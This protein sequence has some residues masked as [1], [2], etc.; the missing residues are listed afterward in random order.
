[1]RILT[2][3]AR[4]FLDTPDDL[5]GKYLIDSQNVVRESWVENVYQI[6]DS[7]FNE[8][9]IFIDVG[10][11]IGAVSLF[12]S[13]F[14]SNRDENN[15]IKIYA[16]EPEIHNLK[17]LSSNVIKNN[18]IE[19][20]KIETSALSTKEGNSYISN[21]GGNSMLTS[22][23]SDCSEIK[24]ITLEQL[25]NKYEINQCDVLKMDIEGSEYEVLINSSLETLKR[26]KYLTLEFTKTNAEQFGELISHLAEIFNLHII[27][28]PSNG[29]YIYGRRY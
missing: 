8:S 13:S 28:R 6:N 20:I 11:N 25:F 22:K 7:D 18:E 17:I 16:V 14:N 12:V 23:N 21:R 10:A 24:T 1:M 9:R 5:V 3:N 27:G 2:P 4:F 29:G 26:I 19:T 15:K